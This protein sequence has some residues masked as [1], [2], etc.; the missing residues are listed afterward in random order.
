[1]CSRIYLEWPWEWAP[2]RLDLSKGEKSMGCPDEHESTEDRLVIYTML[3]CCW[4]LSAGGCGSIDWVI[5]RAGKL[6]YKLLVV[7]A[8]FVVDAASAEAIRSYVRDGAP[9]L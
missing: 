8:D 3:F 7:P 2:Q 1:M 9:S 5:G 6:D 4:K